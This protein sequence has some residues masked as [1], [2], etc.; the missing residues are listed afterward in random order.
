MAWASWSARYAEPVG[1]PPLAGAG[2]KTANLGACWASMAK[3]GRLAF[4]G[5]AVR[6]T[7][8]NRAVLV[9]VFTGRVALAVLSSSSS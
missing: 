8:L 4:G 6:L 3:A 1:G 7:L 9:T 2:I 5:R